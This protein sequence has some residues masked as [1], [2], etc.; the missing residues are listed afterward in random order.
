MAETATN[1]TDK[2]KFGVL[3]IFFEVDSTAT[4]TFF[5]KW[6]IT[7]VSTTATSIV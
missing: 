7:K 1:D 4:T 3:V 2:R 6:D 5:S